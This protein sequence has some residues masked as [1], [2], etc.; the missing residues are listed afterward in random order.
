MKQQRIR[1]IQLALIFAFV[2]VLSTATSAQ[3]RLREPEYFVN[4]D[5]KAACELNA[6]YLDILLLAARNGG[7][8]IF[9]ISRIGHK[10]SS[11]LNRIR[12]TNAKKV[13]TDGKQFPDDRIVTAIGDRVA[14]NQNG[15]L[16]FYLGGQL[17]LV[18]EIGKNKSAC[19]SCCDSL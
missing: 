14:G 16:E 4:S 12:L 11:V 9:V 3:D 6:S 17:F 7:N 15:R 10:E 2:F 18:T 1:Q 5:D 8:R 19:L 13:M